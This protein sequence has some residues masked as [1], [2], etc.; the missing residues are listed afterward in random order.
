MVTAI[1]HYTSMKITWQPDH[2]SSHQQRRDT[3][4]KSWQTEP[5]TREWLYIKNGTSVKMHII[6]RSSWKAAISNLEKFYYRLH[7]RMNLFPHPGQNTTGPT[8]SR[9]NIA[10]VLRRK[11]MGITLTPHNKKTPVIRGT[12]DQRQHASQP[13]TQRFDDCYNLQ[14]HTI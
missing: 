9:L 13:H 5:S 4:I 6:A 8:L 12:P 2:P 7:V 10:C 3:K 1:T 11:C 14:Y